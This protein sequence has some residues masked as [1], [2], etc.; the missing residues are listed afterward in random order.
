MYGLDRKGR[1]FVH[2]KVFKQ[3][4]VYGEM[5]VH[6]GEVKIRCRE[7]LRWH[8][9]TILSPDSSR[10]ILRETQTPVEVDGPDNV[11]SVATQEGGESK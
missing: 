3:N 11:V 6:G 9:I 7:C 8:N 5:L 2:I 10:A 1:L 4:R